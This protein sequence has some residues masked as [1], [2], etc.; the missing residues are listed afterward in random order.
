MIGVSASLRE[1]GIFAHGTPELIRYEGHLGRYFS[2]EYQRLL[3]NPE[4]QALDT[5]TTNRGPMWKDTRAL[6]ENHYN[7]HV[8]PFSG[9]LD[10]EFMAYTMAYYGETAHDVASSKLSLEEAERNKFELV[11][12]RAEIH[13]DEKIFNIGCGYGPLETYLFTAFPKVDI[14][15]ITPS[16][17]QID[18]IE[19]CRANTN[20]PISRG[21][22]RLIQGDFSE[23]PLSEL[24]DRE[25]DR[26]FSIGCFEH[27]NNLDA[28]F[29]L[30]D[31]LLKPG[32]L[33]FLHMVASRLIV[34]QFLHDDKTMIGT[35]FPG[36]KIWPFEII[37]RQDRFMRLSKS[38]FINGMNYWKTIDEWHKR[39]WH[40][41][42]TLYGSAI[43]DETEAKYWN[44]YF[45]LCKACFLPSKG[46]LFGNGHFVFRKKT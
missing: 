10:H 24:G 18:F 35:Y 39:L 7:A 21:K 8:T 29:E 26:V 31:K 43:K 36:G 13:G 12:R 9:F 11:C 45:V 41:M 15:S 2:R 16:P 22:L 38:W 20:H 34:P 6:I 44:D 28:V 23:V 40:N 5:V 3:H 33:F 25:Y 42:D 17:D 30:I 1:A 46:E 37:R 32:G 19:S 4:S 27:I 14:T